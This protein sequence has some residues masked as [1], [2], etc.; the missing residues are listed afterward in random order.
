MAHPSAQIKVDLRLTKRRL[1]YEMSFM[2]VEKSW[3][4]SQMTQQSNIAV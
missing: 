4:V 3:H 2:K 1:S